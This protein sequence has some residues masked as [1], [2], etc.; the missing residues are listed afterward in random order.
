VWCG[1]FEGH[2]FGLAPGIVLRIL[3]DLSLRR[4]FSGRSRLH[5]RSSAVKTMSV[6]GGNAL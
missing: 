5:Q 3:H 4:V 6:T 2:A 1:E